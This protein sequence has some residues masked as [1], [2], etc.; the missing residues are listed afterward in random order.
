M[1]MARWPTQESK[2]DHRPFKSRFDFVPKK[3]RRGGVC[4]PKQR[5]GR[6]R[7]TYMRA[8]PISYR[9]GA[10]IGQARWGPLLMMRPAARPLPCN[11][12][13]RIIQFKKVLVIGCV[14]FEIGNRA[15]KILKIEHSPLNFAL[16]F[17]LD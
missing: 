6:G 15:P 2:A 16:C 9:Y 8:Y 1:H 5:E 7:P 13:R 12:R 10:C 11:V 3:N 14:V 17:G 4:R